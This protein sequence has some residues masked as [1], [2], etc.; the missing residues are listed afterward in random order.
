MDDRLIKPV[1]GN[2]NIIGITSAKDLKEKKKRQDFSGKQ[3]QEN[4][5]IQD[6]IIE[7]DGEKIKVDVPV[8][9]KNKNSIDFCA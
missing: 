8:V 3:N 1:E 2:Q 5:I 6:E 4:Q 9:E 7:S